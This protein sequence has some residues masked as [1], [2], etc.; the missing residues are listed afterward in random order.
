MVSTTVSLFSHAPYPLANTLDYAGDPGLCGPD[1][2][3]WPVIGDA[4]A[5]I[6]GIRALLTQAAHPEVVAGVA[7]HSSYRKDP[8]GRLSR[9]SAYVT[10]TSFGAIPEVEA[11]LAMVRT[12]HAPVRGRSHRDRPYSA[13]AAPLASWVHNAL[14]DSFL[15]AYMAYGPRPLSAAEADR[16]VIEQGAI[17]RMLNATDLPETA[18]ELGVW[19]KDHPEL[20]HSPGLVEAVAFLRKPPLPWHVRVPY[21]MMVVAAVATLPPRV[22]K[23]LGVRRIPGAR[24]LGRSIIAALRWALGSSP[25]W[26]VALVRAGAPVPPG[27]FRQRPPLGK[28]PQDSGLASGPAPD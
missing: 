20:G 11:A 19:I 15:Q 23:I 21:R 25:S 4:S 3:T 26:H 10:A 2:V 9:T 12:A 1:S 27:R 7:D 5:F 6:G 8:L 18:V 17:G 22:R 14:T 16:F 13:G 24:I 28:L